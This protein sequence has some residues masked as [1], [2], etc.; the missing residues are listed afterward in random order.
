VIVPA[1]LSEAPS[2]IC[3]DLTS[4]GGVVY[5][6]SREDTMIDRHVSGA[7]VAAALLWALTA[8]M[9]VTA[10]GVALVGHWNAGFMLGL[11]ACATSAAAA[12]MQV[13]FFATKI[14]NLM[15]SLH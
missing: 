7:A 13:R 4:T 15:R 10:W 14:C 12:T 6:N 9:A 8:T 1:G 3:P 11:T 5:P 2:T